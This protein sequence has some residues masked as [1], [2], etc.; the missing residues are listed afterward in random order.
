MESHE[1]AGAAESVVGDGKR[2]G[3]ALGCR[4]LRH[5]DKALSGLPVAQEC[6]EFGVWEARNYRLHVDGSRSRRFPLV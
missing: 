4:A 2:P 5:R 6:L 1:R 3:L